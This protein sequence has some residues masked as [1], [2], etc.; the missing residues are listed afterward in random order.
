MLPPHIP[1]LSLFQTIGS[2]ELKVIVYELL[3]TVEE[4]YDQ[5]DYHGS[6]EKFFSLVEKCADKRPVS[7][8]CAVKVLIC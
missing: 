8:L 4:L 3:T 5:N 6:T 2:A 7:A 1:P